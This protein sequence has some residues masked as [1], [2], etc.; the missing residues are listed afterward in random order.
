MYEFYSSVEHVK[1]END[2]TNN[3]I[4]FQMLNENHSLT[5]REFDEHFDLPW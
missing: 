4:N 3:T 1:D 2:Y 5:K